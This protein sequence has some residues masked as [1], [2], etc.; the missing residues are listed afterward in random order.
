MFQYLNIY[1]HTFHRFVC[2][3]RSFHFE[4][5]EGM[6]GVMLQFMRRDRAV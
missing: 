3:R 1:D 5:T 2:Y 6:Q 4:N